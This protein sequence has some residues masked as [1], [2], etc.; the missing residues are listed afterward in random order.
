[1]TAVSQ[2]LN[3]HESQP[4]SHKQTNGY[5]EAFLVFAIRNQAPEPDVQQEIELLH[6][7]INIQ[8]G[9]IPG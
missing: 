6:T 3:I 8:I 9:H 1:M 4:Y 7:E 2:L 5:S